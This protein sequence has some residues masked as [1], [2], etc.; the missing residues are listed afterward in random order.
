MTR[1]LFGTALAAAIGCIGIGCTGIQPVGPMAK[2]FDTNEK[3]KDATPT[4]PVTIPA[5]K[6]TP[7]L[8]IVTPDEVDRDPYVAAQ[9]LTTEFEAD[10][11]SMPS[12]PQTAEVSVYKGGV[13]QN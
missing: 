8:S 10:R 9:K 12:A 13:K 1:I 6:P 11:K 7:P 2:V 4:Q 3:S 5:P